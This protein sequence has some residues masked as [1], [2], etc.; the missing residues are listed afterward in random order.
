MTRGVSYIEMVMADT[1][2][3]ST[4][5]LVSS[6]GHDS[7]SPLVGRLGK[8]EDPPAIAGVPPLACKQRMH[9]L[10]YRNVRHLSDWGDYTPG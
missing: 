8:E 5:S 7:R 6:T 10:F 1:G 4:R 3:M 9:V 2:K